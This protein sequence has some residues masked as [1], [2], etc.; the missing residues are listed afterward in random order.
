[1]AQGSSIGLVQWNLRE[2]GDYII[3]ATSRK[4]NLKIARVKEIFE[5]YK[6]RGIDIYINKT[7]VVCNII[8][9]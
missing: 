5:Q 8:T 2:K 4:V 9:I 3:A 1:M 6:E 7:K